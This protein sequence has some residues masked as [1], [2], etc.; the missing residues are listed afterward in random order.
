MYGA[1]FFPLESRGESKRDGKVLYRGIYDPKGDSSRPIFREIWEG[2][3][4]ATRGVANPGV[5]CFLR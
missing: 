5:G 1:T 2:D 4:L 3:F